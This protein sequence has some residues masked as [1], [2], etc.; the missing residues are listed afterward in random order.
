MDASIGKPRTRPSGT[1][2][3]GGGALHLTLPSIETAARIDFDTYGHGE[4]SSSRAFSSTALIC[5]VH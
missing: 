1:D 2:D 5:E 3:D 4:R